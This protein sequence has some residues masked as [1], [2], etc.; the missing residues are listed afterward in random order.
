[1][2]STTTV[3]ERSGE[4]SDQKLILQAYGG[5]I[6]DIQSLPSFPADT[7]IEVLQQHFK[8]HGVLWV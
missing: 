6:E 8:E 5:A 1:M 3:T 2:S 7:P 4:Q